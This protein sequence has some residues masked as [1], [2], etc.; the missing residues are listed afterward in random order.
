MGISRRSLFKY[1]IDE[2][3][4]LLEETR[5]RQSFRLSDLARLENDKL[6]RLIPA[7]MDASRVRVIADRVVVDHQQ[8]QDVLYDVGSMEADVWPRIDGRTSLQNIATSLAPVWGDGDA[9]AFGRV[10][11]LFL[12]LVDVGICLPLNSAD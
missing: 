5:G 11:R 2:V 12:A 4:A 10:R 6:G 8:R 1:S 9:A 7:I 3:V